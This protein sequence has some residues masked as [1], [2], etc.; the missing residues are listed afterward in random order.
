MSSLLCL[1]VNHPNAT[2]WLL[3]SLVTPPLPFHHPTGLP[4]ATPSTKVSP[5]QDYK[6]SPRD[7]KG[8]I[9]RGQMQPSLV[10]LAQE[11][12]I[13]LAVNA[14]KGL[15]RAISL[16]TRKYSSSV[17]QDMLCTSRIL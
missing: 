6:L 17:A 13:P 16:G 7:R 4:S 1:V 11:V 2:L 10:S 15:M 5:R 14:A 8:S 3:I 9:S 12:V